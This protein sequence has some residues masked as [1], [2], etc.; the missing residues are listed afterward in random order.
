MQGHPA[1]VSPKES[2]GTGRGG[3]GMLLHPAQASQMLMPEA[4]D[5]ALGPINEELLTWSLWDPAGRSSWGLWHSFCTKHCVID[6]SRI[7]EYF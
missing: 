5:T 7:K 2:Q 4:W 1:L 3:E 6:N